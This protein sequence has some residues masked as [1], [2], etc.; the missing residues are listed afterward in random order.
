METWLLAKCLGFDIKPY[1][2]LSFKVIGHYSF[3][4]VKVFKI[5]ATGEMVPSLTNLLTYRNRLLYYR[6]C[7]AETYL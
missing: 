2:C 3:T 7:I 6:P 5:I 1:K 4:G